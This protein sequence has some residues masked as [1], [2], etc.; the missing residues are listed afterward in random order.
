MSA[1]DRTFVQES[2]RGQPPTLHSV[3]RLLRLSRGKKGMY[4]TQIRNI[5]AAIGQNIKY[6]NHILTGTSTFYGQ[7]QT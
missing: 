2:V 6:I 5:E 4:V 7:R 1:G 3:G